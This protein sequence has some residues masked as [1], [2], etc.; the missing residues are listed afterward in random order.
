M[1]FKRPTWAIV[2]AVVAIVV[3]A[4][5]ASAATRYLIT[6]THQ[7]KPSVLKQLRGK[8]GPRGL[9]GAKGGQGV[10]GAAGT[11]RAVA[12]VQSYGG[13][14][15]GVGYPKNITGVSHTTGSG[16]YCVI[17]ASGVGD[18]SDAVVSLTGIPPT[19]SSVFVQ[20]GN[21]DCAPGELEV[22]TTAVELFGD[23]V[24]DDLNLQSVP[25]DAGFTV[26]VP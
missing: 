15:Q 9:T 2:A 24:D 26:L 16:I 20:P 11:A 8:R 14:T 25:T 22:E 13:L 1:T 18:A 10:A 12:V 19:G 17:L 5:G 7:I 4:A 6:S 3:V 23:A 21:L